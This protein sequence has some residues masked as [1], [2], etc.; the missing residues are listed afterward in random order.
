MVLLGNDLKNSLDFIFF[1]TEKKTIHKNKNFF[2][3]IF[4]FH[5]IINKIHKNR[6][7]KKKTGWIPVYGK[8]NVT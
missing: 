6:T 5:K 3:K 1:F 4:F 2:T 8:L 7:L